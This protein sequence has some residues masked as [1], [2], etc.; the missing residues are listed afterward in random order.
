MEVRHM[1]T[2]K[3][4]HSERRVYI[5]PE[6][7]VHGTVAEITAQNKDWG[8]GDAMTFQNQSTRITS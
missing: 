3:R 5:T 2:E 1:P 7:I 4:E 6:L 8:S